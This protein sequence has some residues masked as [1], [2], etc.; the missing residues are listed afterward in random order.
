MVLADCG[1]TIRTDLIRRKC[2][3]AIPAFLDGRAQLSDTKVTEMRRIANLRI[4]VHVK[5]SI[6][7]LKRFR[8]LSKMAGHST[9][10]MNLCLGACVFLTNFGNSLTQLIL[11]S[12][13]SLSM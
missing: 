4:H 9:G 13:F 8:F 11:S 6:G 1:F 12:S 2:S 7:R 10:V 5:R 3:L